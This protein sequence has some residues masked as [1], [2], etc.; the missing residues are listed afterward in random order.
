MTIIYQF[1][2]YNLE[3]LIR[4]GMSLIILQGT[5]QHGKFQFIFLAK[6]YHTSMD[7]A[8]GMICWAFVAH[9]ETS[10]YGFR[11]VYSGSETVRLRLVHF[12]F[13]LNEYISELC[14]TYSKSIFAESLRTPNLPLPIL[15]EVWRRVVLLLQTLLVQHRLQMKE[16]GLLASI[17]LAHS[18]WTATSLCFGHPKTSSTQQNKTKWV[19][20]ISNK[21]DGVRC[22]TLI[23]CIRASPFAQMR[24]NCVI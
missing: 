11:F 22:T 6:L 2:E 7:I 15:V 3:V 17:Q 10:N 5:R 1:K 20:Y 24:L 8:N 12:P 18:F 13:H 9:W 23:W 21:C 4:L 14:F 19:N 16:I